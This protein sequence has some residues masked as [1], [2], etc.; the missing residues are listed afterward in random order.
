VSVEDKWRYRFSTPDFVALFVIITV[1]SI[2]SFI[3]VILKWSKWGFISVFTNRLGMWFE[4]D[5]HTL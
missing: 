1:Y 2:W 4:F 5:P 3:G